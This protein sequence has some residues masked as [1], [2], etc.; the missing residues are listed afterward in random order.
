[1]LILTGNV[2][3]RRLPSR[4]QQANSPSTP[5]HG[6]VRPSFPKRQNSGTDPSYRSESIIMT[7]SELGISRQQA[8][9]EISV[10]SHQAAAAVKMED[11]DNDL[12]DRIRKTELFKPIIGQLEEFL[13]LKSFME[14]RPNGWTNSQDL[15]VKLRAL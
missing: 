8:H 12:I 3:S 15:V 2:R 1:M 10:L 7:L 6:Y 4:H 13:E 9:E 11:K 14:E 5:L